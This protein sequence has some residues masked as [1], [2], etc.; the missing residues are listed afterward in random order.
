[1]VEE[2]SSLAITPTWSLAT[3]TTVMVSFGFFFQ[4]SLNRCR[5][6]LDKTK[7]KALVSALEKIKD[8][9]MVFGLLSL[10]MGHWVVVVAKVCIR[11]SSANSKFFPCAERNVVRLELSRSESSGYRNDSSAT[12][13]MFAVVNTH[14]HCPE[15]H[16]P[17]ASKESLEQLHRLMFALGV[18]HVLYSFIAIAL[19]LIKIHS[20]KVWEK[21]GQSTAFQSGEGSV[22]SRHAAFNNTQVAAFISHN[23]SH[24]WSGNRFLVWLLCFCRQ[25]WSSINYADYMALRY[26]FITKHELP[27][28][29]DFQGYML[30]SMEEEFRDI[31]GMSLPLWIYAMCCIFL[32]FHESNVYFWISFLPAILVLLIGTKLHRVVVKLAVEIMGTAPRLGNLP[33]NLRNE[34]FWF[35]KPKLLLW[36]IQLI[37]F[38]NAFEMAAFLWSLWEIR[39]SSC[40]MTN[41]WFIAIRLV[42]GVVAQFWC[43]F[44]TF[45]LYIIVTQMDA[46]LKR[47]VV[48]EGVR[49]SIHGWTRRVKAKHHTA[50]SSLSSH[51]K[52]SSTSTMISSTSELQID[53]SADTE[54]TYEMVSHV[55]RDEILS[56]MEITEA[57]ICSDILYDSDEDSDENTATPLFKN[58]QT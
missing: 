51:V 25:F 33:L 42:F 36:L 27:L 30:R 4:F 22:G 40:F 13:Q 20:W 1:M 52:D 14:H 57:P 47:T 26:G 17:F 18:V 46:R 55:N 11:A 19:A 24:P 58:L 32:D 38:Q 7:R 8:E 9:L 35:G 50:S 15:G 45:P 6:Y 29:Y 3:V 10:L 37:T 54:N 56:E 41:Q 53:E 12:G 2:K 39:D 44:I 5:K 31:V 48:S 49:K 16:E 43:S 23:A 21:Q 28:T 34:L